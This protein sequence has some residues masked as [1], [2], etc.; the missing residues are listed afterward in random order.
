M[1]KE[2]IREGYLTMDWNEF[3]RLQKLLSMDSQLRQLKMR[4]SDYDFYKK[5]A[6]KKD[7]EENNHQKL[8]SDHKR[9]IFLI[10]N[11]SVSEA[12]KTDQ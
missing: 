7:I 5:K 2:R 12:L 3:E 4:S 1:I 10:K 8:L 9:N 6:K 11:L